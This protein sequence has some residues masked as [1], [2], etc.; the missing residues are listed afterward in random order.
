M[1][2]YFLYLYW[3]P[4][5]EI[6]KTLTLLFLSASD[7]I[8]SWCCVFLLLLSTRWNCELYIFPDHAALHATE[9]QFR[10]CGSREDFTLIRFS[11]VQEAAQSLCHWVTTTP[12]R[13]HSASCSPAPAHHSPS[14]FNSKSMRV[15][16]KPKLKSSPIELFGLNRWRRHNFLLCYISHCLLVIHAYTPP[17]THAHTYTHT[18]FVV[19]AAR[20]VS[21]A[22]AIAFVLLYFRYFCLDCSS[23]PSFTCS[24]PPLFPRPL[25]PS[26]FGTQFDVW[27]ILIL[28]FFCVCQLTVKTNDTEK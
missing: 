14:P 18:V 12:V 5:E 9:N 22:L 2:Q 1:W 20:S 8:C 24:F 27:S 16:P 26:I 11:Y 17:C 21:L 25:P 19:A 6:E 15:F 3:S 28:F 23:P 4:K 10:L 13:S 7:K